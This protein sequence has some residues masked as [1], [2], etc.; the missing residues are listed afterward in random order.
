MADKDAAKKEMYSFRDEYAAYFEQ[1]ASF[2]NNILVDWDETDLGESFSKLRTKGKKMAVGTSSKKAAKDDEEKEPRK[3][4][5]E[6]GGNKIILPTDMDLDEA[7]E[8]IGRQR[9]EESV[10]VAISEQI[11]AFPF[12]GAVA[13]MRVL[14]RRYGWTHLKPTPGFWGSSPPTMVGVEIN[15]GERVQVPWG[16]MAVPKIEGT[17]STSYAFKDGMPRFVLAGEVMRKNERTVQAIAQEIRDEVKKNSIYRAKAVKINFRDQNQ[18]RREF[19]T[20]LCPKFIDM[21]SVGDTT[22]IFAK[23]IEDAIRINVLNPLR[24]SKRCRAKGASLKK[25]IILGGPYGTGKTLTAYQIAKIAVDNGWTFLYLEDVRDL[26]LA[27]GFAK[28]YG[29][30]VLFAE[31]ADKATLGPRNPEMDRLLNV[32]DGVESKGADSLITVLTTN[33]IG[34]INPA[35]LRPGR[36]DAVINVTPPDAEACVRI[37]KKY[38][39]DGGCVLEGTDAELQE[40]VAPL[41][42]ANAAF[43]RNA[44]EQCKL[45]AMEHMETDDSPLVIRPSDLRTVAEGMLPHCRLINPDHGK[46]SLLDMEEVHHEPMQFAMDILVHKFAEGMINMV[47]DPKV[48]SKIVMKQMKPRGNLGGPPSAN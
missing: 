23:S 14:Q 15:H 35:F 25:G 37:I 38:V 20:S 1:S 3:V 27:I 39:A 30:C 29:P 2:L 13:M 43:L 6:Y 36:I 42:G 7:Y 41:L 17:L 9:D 16:R 28:L 33:N 44:V 5:V 4:D 48:L 34:I 21:V 10:Y 8:A 24:F 47:A 45:A 22:P 12:D 19:D 26:D 31:D 32:I 18:E 40:C 46:K 11:D